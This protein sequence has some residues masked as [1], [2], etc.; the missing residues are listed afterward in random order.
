MLSNHQVD[1]GSDGQGGAPQLDVHQVS[2]LRPLVQSVLHEMASPLSAIDALARDL[3]GREDGQADAV[4]RARLEKI[5]LAADEL[6]SILQAAREALAGSGRGG[7]GERATLRAVLDSA[8][9]SAGRFSPYHP[10]TLKV[11]ADVADVPCDAPLLGLVLRTLLD[12]AMKYTPAGTPVKVR[13]C[14]SA[15]GVQIRVEDQGPG[16]ARDELPRLFELHYRAH[17]AVRQPGTGMGLALARQLMVMQGGS[18]TAIQPLGRGLCLLAFLPV[19]VP[20]P[21]LQAL[22]NPAS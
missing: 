9:T 18:L 10:L 5:L 11:D 12:N 16:V 19:P 15:G 22:A 8:V 3:L 6:R 7:K 14:A 17:N 21:T 13:A 1:F 2:D 4:Q 20:S